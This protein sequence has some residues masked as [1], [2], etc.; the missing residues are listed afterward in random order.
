MPPGPRSPPPKLIGAPNWPVITTLPLCASVATLAALEVPPPPIV[1]AHRQLPSRPEYLARN[2]SIVPTAVRAPLP[3]S[4]VPEKLPAASTSPDRST[5]TLTT[6]SL[7]LPPQ[8]LAHRTVPSAAIFTKAIS[9]P[10]AVE[11]VT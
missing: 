2:I 4:V 7:P 1:L 5:A 11:R 6:L 8:R 10:P 3:T 9:I